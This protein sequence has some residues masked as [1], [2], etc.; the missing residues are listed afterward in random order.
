M[1][2]LTWC[3]EHRPQLSRLVHRF[4]DLKTNKLIRVPHPLLQSTNAIKGGGEACWGYIFKIDSLGLQWAR[5]I[6]GTE[7]ETTINLTSRS[8]LTLF[9]VFACLVSLP[10]CVY[11]VSALLLNYVWSSSLIPLIKKTM[12]HPV[13]ISC[14]SWTMVCTCPLTMTPTETELA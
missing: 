1:Y 10:L 2:G 11:I 6:L 12:T 3:M 9:S 4:L 7:G 13:V 5:A 8:T 14:A